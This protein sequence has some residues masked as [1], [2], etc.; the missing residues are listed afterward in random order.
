M[1]LALFD[2]DNTITN[3]DSFADFI[4]FAAGS[5]HFYIGVVLIIPVVLLF[6]FRLMR[7]GTTKEMMTAYF[8]GGWEVGEFQEVASRYSRERIPHIV[9]DVAME[10]IRWHK[11]QG[12]DIAV[13]SASLEPWLKG[14]CDDQGIELI[15]T[16]LRMDN[17][18]ITGRFSGRTCSGKEKVRRIKECYDLS[19]YDYIYAYG[20]NHGD[21]PMLEMADE[22]Y[23]RWRRI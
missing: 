4:K 10:K 23:Y 12:H 20:D 19:R 5:V 8:F 17:G 18:W 6:L 7:A 14:W 16:K 13:V 21:R 22:K 9:R 2:F 15:A 11:E 3:R 1:R